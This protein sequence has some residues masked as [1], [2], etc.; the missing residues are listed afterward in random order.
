VEDR[1]KLMKQ[2]Q[3]Q[4][5]THTCPKCKG[6]AY[7]AMADGKSANL[8]WCMTVEKDENPMAA[9]TDQCLCRTCLT[10]SPDPTHLNLCSGP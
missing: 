5:S 7:C 6:R 8:C 10:A 1:V 4:T 3:G 9:E 2:I